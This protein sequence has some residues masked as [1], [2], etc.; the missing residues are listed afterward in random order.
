MRV[1]MVN[2]RKELSLTQ[3]EVANKSGIARTTY[4]NIELG[5]KNPSLAVA[6]R[7]KKA[8]NVKNDD[9]FLIINVPDGNKGNQ[10][11]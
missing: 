11:A 10:I 7:L 6:L 9:I 2:R 3:E 8:L 4:T 1:N 5:D